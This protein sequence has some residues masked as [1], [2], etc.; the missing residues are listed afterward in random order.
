LTTETAAISSVI[1]KYVYLFSKCGINRAEFQQV[2]GK[3]TG[4]IQL[5]AENISMSVNG[6]SFIGCPWWRNASKPFLLYPCISGTVVLPAV[7]FKCAG[8]L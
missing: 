6:K 5:A 8:K 2:L 4:A 3:M 1:A 7:A